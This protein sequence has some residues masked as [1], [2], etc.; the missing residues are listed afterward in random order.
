[1][2]VSADN[3]FGDDKIVYAYS[4]SHRENSAVNAGE[5]TVTVTLGTGGKTGNYVLRSAAGYSDDFVIA[6]RTLTVTFAGEYEIEYGGTRPAFA[7]VYDGWADGENKTALGVSEDFAVTRGGVS[8]EPG[9][10]YG[11][12]GIY[13]VT[14]TISGT[15]DNYAINGGSGF[16]VTT[17][18]EVT[19]RALKL[20]V[21]AEDKTYD[22]EAVTVSVTADRALPGDVIV[23]EFAYTVGG[24]ADGS[25]SARPPR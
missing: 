5:Y 20:T 9:A 7:L 25:L 12:V 2:T 22:G 17:E 4:Y 6:K 24:I 19:P 3:R 18:M 10:E 1:M 8:Y 15:L 13:D 16:T 23:W 14:A 11:S 21:T